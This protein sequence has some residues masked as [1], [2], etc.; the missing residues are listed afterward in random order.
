MA[1]A[2]ALDVDELIERGL[3]AQ[4]AGDSGRAAELYRSALAIAPNCFDALQLLGLT[5]LQSG[6]QTEGIVLLERAVA[7]SPGEVGALN[8]LGAALREVRRYREAVDAFRR[9]LAVDPFRVEVLL[10]LAMTLMQVSEFS[11]AA[12][13]IERARGREPLNPMVEYM[14]AHLLHATRRSAEAVVA[15][16][17]SIEL[18]QGG[19][20][21]RMSLGLALQESGRDVE[22]GD[23]FTAA[24]ALAPT[25]AV[26]LF[27]A[28]TALQSARWDRFAQDSASLAAAHTDAASVDPWRLMLFPVSGNCARVLAERYAAIM[29]AAG[30]ALRRG[31]APTPRAADGGRGRIR[32]AYLSPDF[33]GHAVGYLISG[34]LDAHDRERFEIYCYGWSEVDRTGMRERIACACD[35]FVEVSDLS[36][37]ALVARLRADALDVV[38]D[39]AG[40]TAKNRSRVLAARVAP[41]QVSWLGYPGTLGGALADYIV[42]DWQVIPEGRESDFSEHVVRLPECCLAFDPTRPIAAPR[43]RAEYGLPDE[44]VVLACFAQTRKINPLVFD[45]WMSVLRQVPQAMLWLAQASST[46]VENLAQEA[47]KRGIERTRIRYAVALDEN[48]DHL[49]RYRVADLALDTFPYGSHSTA[50][51]ALWAGCPLVALAGDTFVSRVSASVL[52]AGGVPELIC[53]DLQSYLELILELSRD[54]P[55]RQALRAKLDNLRPSSPLF[56]SRR[57]TRALEH[58]FG[59]MHQRT[60]QELKPQS[61]SV[62]L[63]DVESELAAT[64]SGETGGVRLSAGRLLKSAFA[65]QQQGLKTEA[66]VLYRRVL[67]LDP[68]CFDALQLLGLLR[69]RDGDL[70]SG[71]ALLEHARQLHPNHP[72]MLNNLGNALRAAGRF[73]EAL[74][75]YRGAVE[76]ESDPHPTMLQ[77]LGSAWYEAGD[78]PKAHEVFTRA[79]TRDPGNLSVRA[80]RAGMAAALAR[81]EHFAEDTGAFEVTEADVAHAFDPA[82]LLMLPLDAA[83][84]RIHAGAYA[85]SLMRAEAAAPPPMPAGRSAQRL[86]I[87]YLSGDFREHAVGYL[88]GDL[89][90]RHRRDCFET[91]AFS[92]GDA[93]AGNVRPRIAAAVDHFRE[94]SQFTDAA[95]RDALRADEID[96]VVDLMGYTHKARPGIFAVRSA[97]IQVNWLGYPGTSGAPFIDYIVADSFIIPPGEDLHYS[98]QVVRLPH[99]YLPYSRNRAIGAPLPRSVYGLPE[100]AVVLVCLGPVAKVNPPVFDR[101]MQILRDHPQTVLWLACHYPPTMKNVQREAQVRGVAADRLVFAPL[102]ADNAQHLARYLVAD[103]ALDTF[104]YGAHSTAVDALWTGCPLVACVGHT[105]ASRVSGSVLTAAGCGELITDHLAAYQELIAQLV[106]NPERRAALRARL[107]NSRDSSPLFDIEGF[108]GG[109]ESAYQ[110]MWSKYQ[111]GEP[112]GA[113]TVRDIEA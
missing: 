33:R 60:V 38:V 113:I 41:V 28:Y 98:E 111:S 17:R 105:F 81:W 13:C 24:E 10:N 85:A 66:E 101:W 77:N 3:K 103:L 109:L 35:Q 8:N 34:V 93:G 74:E 73:D 2:I 76:T 49:A 70:E 45:A 106:E 83:A 4:R 19:A 75:A 88:V 27:R 21:V 84:L 47:E 37:E 59:R 78:L 26:R 87:A 90:E 69:F 92:W 65:L 99:A 51:D 64:A 16:Q 68:N 9:A 30:A 67:A 40:Y 55:R 57:F 110:S 50:A 94:V 112:P 96:I 97:P 102:L 11:F 86:R 42:A 23:A 89:F 32:I 61:F 54:A 18:G 31:E 1:S 63:G 14:Y 44:A 72:A 52:E 108:V 79:V 80:D 62:S 82:R 5:H 46:A 39:L 104:P 48:A 95:I 56:D 15:F 22:A 71:I 6:Q 7:V 43:T 58:A 91:F 107:L 25:P 100:N 20:E 12:R 53:H 29:S 36:D